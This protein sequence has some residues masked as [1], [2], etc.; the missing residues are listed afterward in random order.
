MT[1]R[2]SHGKI[3]FPGPARCCFLGEPSSDIV[4]RQLLMQPFSDLTPCLYLGLLLQLVSKLSDFVVR[5]RPH[6]CWRQLLVTRACSLSTIDERH[7]KLVLLIH[8][9]E[10]F[11]DSKMQSPSYH[12]CKWID[13][14]F[15]WSG[16]STKS[17]DQ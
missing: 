7:K 12:Q 9:P 4:L 17:K 6:G 5:R 11:K 1:S 2:S 10:P 14:M 8:R 16:E 3:V 13:S 15:G